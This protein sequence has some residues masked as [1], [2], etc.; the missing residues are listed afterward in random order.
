M[1][2]DL[3]PCKLRSLSLHLIGQFKDASF[4]HRDYHSKCHLSKSLQT[5][6]HLIQS[7]GMVDTITNH[8]CFCRNSSTKIQSVRNHQAV[9]L[10]THTNHFLAATACDLTAELE[11]D[12]STSTQKV[13]RLLFLSRSTFQRSAS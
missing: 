12:R 3:Y 7:S 11:Y 10:S 8:F 6:N 4:S 13:V 2:R 1:Q 5:L 9:N